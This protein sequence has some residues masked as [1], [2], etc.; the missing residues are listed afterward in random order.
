MRVLASLIGIIM[1]TAASPSFAQERFDAG[2]RIG[3]GL[4]AG[5]PANDMPG[6]GVFG[7]YRL[8]DHWA[9]GLAL[10]TTEFDFEEP[11]KRLRLPVGPDDEV[12]DTKA[13]ATIVSAWLERRFPRDRSRGEW[14]V[15][16]GLGVSSLDV[17]DARGSL[18]GGGSFDI[19]TDGGTEYLVTALGGRRYRLGNRWSI[20]LGL[21][22]E[23]HFAD[24]KLEDRVS[25]ATR[26]IDDYFAYGAHLG[27][28][29]R[30]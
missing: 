15:G 22:A 3:L 18:P 1:V 4:A 2:V 12:V 25:G 30:F 9:L 5:V 13:K 10:D 14:F 26:T 8:T 28:S 17:P 19:V 24:W 7:H 20:E 27:F 16:S 23:Q 21:R 6:Q 29:I 11:A